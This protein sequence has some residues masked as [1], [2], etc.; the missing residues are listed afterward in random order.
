MP[1]VWQITFAVTPAGGVTDSA[2]ITFC[3]DG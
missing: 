1:G 3:V 2:V